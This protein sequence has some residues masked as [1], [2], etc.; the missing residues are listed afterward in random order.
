MVNLGAD[1]QKIRETPKVLREEFDMKELNNTEVKIVDMISK[2][3][4]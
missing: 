1:W 2:S 4:K 3:T